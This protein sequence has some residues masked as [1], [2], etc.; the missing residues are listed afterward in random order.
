MNK[1]LIVSCLFVLGVFTPLSAKDTEIRIAETVLYVGEASN[2]TPFGRGTLYV[3][4]RPS[5]DSELRQDVIT[6]VFKGK[7]VHD[8]KIT[9]ASGCLFEGDVIYDIENAPGEDSSYSLEIT[10]TLT[11]RLWDEKEPDD[12]IRFR[13]AVEPLKLD[14]H[15][16][17]EKLKR[18]VK[19][20]EILLVPVTID[21]NQWVGD[22][23]WGSNYATYVGESPVF[24]S[25]TYGLKEII[26]YGREGREY[27]WVF[28]AERTAYPHDYES[29][30]GHVLTEYDSTNPYSNGFSVQYP[31]ADFFEVENH[32]LQKLIK[33]FPEGIAHIDGMDSHIYYN[34]GGMYSGSFSINGIGYGS[35]IYSSR[36][37]NALALCDIMKP[38]VFLDECM[39]M[40]IKGT[41]TSPD[42]KIENWENGITDYQQNKINGNYDKVSAVV[43]Q[44]R[45]QEKAARG[46]ELEK[47]WQTALPELRGK[48]GK[49]NVDAVYNYRMNRKIPVELFE[50]LARLGL[51]RLIGPIYSPNSK[52]SV[53]EYVIYMTNR[54]TGEMQYSLVLKFV[55]PFRSSPDWI[56]DRY[57][58]EFSY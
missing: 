11:G 8:A 5:E 35:Y 45:R 50:D 31:N 46:A 28:F 3:M 13:A 55:H 53:N 23:S 33:S 6:G 10:Y 37:D 15:L 29:V 48:Y 32:R 30:F 54:K 7:E 40:Y 42:G 4:N 52:N 2:T 41:Y 24:H 18:E 21:C 39:L 51:I 56:L 36:D 47:K 27:H 58:S 43:E 25:V 26:E 20:K 49:E 38:D 12:E 57:S 16:N 34:D 14:I 17:G 9:F 1:F 44:A 22:I 19:E